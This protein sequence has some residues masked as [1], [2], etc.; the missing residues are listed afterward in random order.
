MRSSTNQDQELRRRKTRNRK[1]N[2][3]M[4]NIVSLRVTDKEKQA[5][6][7]ITQASS[8]SVSDIVREALHFWITSKK[9]VS[10]DS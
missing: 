10:R 4:T 8:K 1:P 7:R 9:R 3:V 2:D 5:L 6:D